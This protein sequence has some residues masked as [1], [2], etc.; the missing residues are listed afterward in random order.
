VAE[1]WVD[2]TQPLNPDSPRMSFLPAPAFRRLRELNAQGPQITAVDLCVHI[3]THVDAPC[4]FIAGGAS[5]EQIPAER[6]LLQG[7]VWRAD[8]GPQGEISLAAVEPASRL[9]RRG[10][11]LLVSS[12]W[13]EIWRE[14]RYAQNPFLSA[15]LARWCVASG[16]SLVGVDCLTPD[17][18]T[19]LR[20]PDFDFP[21]HRT[22][23]G[24]DVL[25]AENLTNLRALE[26]RRVELMLLPIP[27]EEA[28][29]SP[30]R[31]MARPAA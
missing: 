28:D 26:G 1:P 8:P 18:P 29:G 19:A 3:G 24:N 30:V 2:L 11:A 16:V 5:I 9:L 22:L 14:P 17:M 10:D 12:G 21:V 15:E 13:G 20:P 25:I 23:L 4:H 6:F 31:A 7:V 27:L